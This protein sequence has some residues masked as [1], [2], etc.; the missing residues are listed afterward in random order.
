M[1]YGVLGNIL[2]DLRSKVIK[3]GICDGVP[4]TAAPVPFALGIIIFMLWSIH[5]LY[6]YVL[7]RAKNVS[8]F[9]YTLYSI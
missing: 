1:M 7:I 5:V 2:C 6:V 9:M 3:R 4:S 8:C